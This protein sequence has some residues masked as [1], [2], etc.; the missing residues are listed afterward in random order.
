MLSIQRYVA[1]SVAA[2]LVGCA[3]ITPTL[4]S[5]N[6]RKLSDALEQSL[7]T[8]VAS[9]DYRSASKLYFQLATARTRMHETSAACAA[10][11]QSLAYYRKAIA[12]ETGTVE[13]VSDQGDDEG[14]QEIRAKFGCTK[15]QF[16]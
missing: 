16:N 6:D 8:V 13:Y 3:T 14:M 1:V 5:D 12:Q 7:P 4:A 2:F 11:T 10:L 15:A 9:A